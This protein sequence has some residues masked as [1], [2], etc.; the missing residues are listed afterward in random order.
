MR[1]HYR[2]FDIQ[3][4][5][6]DAWSAVIVKSETGRRWSKAPTATLDEGQEVCVRRARN[7]VDTYLALNVK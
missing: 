1:T 3:L 6:A 2:G 4:E 7:L 5:A